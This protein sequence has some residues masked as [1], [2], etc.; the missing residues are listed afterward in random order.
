MY[1]FK[2]EIVNTKI[3]DY[4]VMTRKSTRGPN[5]VPT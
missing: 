4:R 5:K 2:Y 1:N 3:S